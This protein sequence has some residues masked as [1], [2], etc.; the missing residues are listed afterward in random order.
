[1]YH[2]DLTS[3]ESVD[4]LCNEI[5]SRHSNFDVAVFL[6]GG[7]DMGDF[8]KTG[9]KEIS[10]MFSLN[11]ETAY[12]ISRKIFLKMKQEGGGRLIFM[13]ARPAIDSKSGVSSIAYSLSKSLV[14]KLSDLFNADGRK[15]GIISHVLLPSIMDTA[16]NRKSNP[17]ADF[18]KWVKPNDVAQTILFCSSGAGSIIREGVIKVYGDS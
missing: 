5:F 1:M 8:E 2:A 13:G 10:A 4:S 6:A 9:Q 17:T 14:V 11:F 18:S 15:H 16:E 12:H 7:F 3:E